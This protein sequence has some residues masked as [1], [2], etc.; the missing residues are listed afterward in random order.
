MSEKHTI[1]LLLSSENKWRE[2]I[3]IFQEKNYKI[4]VSIYLYKVYF[5]K[6]N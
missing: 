2:I 4:S 6:E 3:K 1:I 5:K